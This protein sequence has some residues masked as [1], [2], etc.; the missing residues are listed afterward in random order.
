MKRELQNAACSLGATAPY[1]ILRAIFGS[2]DFIT[3]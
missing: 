3:T 2:R 1:A